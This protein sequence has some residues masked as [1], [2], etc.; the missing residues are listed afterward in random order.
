MDKPQPPIWFENGYSTHELWGAIHFG[1]RRIPTWVFSGTWFIIAGI[2]LLISLIG[3]FT[4]D[5]ELGMEARYSWFALIGWF[6]GV[7]AVIG[8]VFGI[9]LF[10]SRA[11]HAVRKDSH[12]N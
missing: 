6:L 2:L 5:Y 4:T 8:G 9:A 11:I 3:Y 1:P 12:G 7:T 10:I